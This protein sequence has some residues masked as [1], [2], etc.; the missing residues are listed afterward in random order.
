MRTSRSI[1]NP[2]R[3]PLKIRDKSG[4]AMPRTLA[5]IRCD[6]N[7]T[8]KRVQAIAFARLGDATSE[9]EVSYSELDVAS[10][11]SRPRDAAPE[12]GNSPRRLTAILAVVIAET[13]LAGHEVPVDPGSWF[14]VL[15]LAGALGLS[16][17][18]MLA[19]R[20]AYR[21]APL[22]W[23]LLAHAGWPLSLAGAIF[24]WRFWV[25]T[26]GPYR[27]NVSYPFGTHLNA[28][29]V[30]FGFTWIA[31]GLLFTTLAV[32]APRATGARSSWLALLVAWVVCWLPHGVIAVGFAR[33]GIDS[34][35]VTDYQA[36][37][38]NP[39]GAAIL[40]ADVLLLLLHA[41]FSVLGF[42]IVGR[43]VW[44]SDSVR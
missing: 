37:G 36:F 30:S 21:A 20:Y 13:R 32:L 8:E 29:A 34:R 43:T 16:A 39:V 5:A 15:T 18:A 28:W 1:E 14:V 42:V 27:A 25:P 24:V 9:H 2:S 19:L 33:G 26:A 6:S 40:I 35:S 12:K 22:G 3:R 44:R 17:G 11:D 31:F 4:W 41:I 23:R 10:V 38:A 7:D